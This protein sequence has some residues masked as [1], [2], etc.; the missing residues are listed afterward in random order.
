M[1][2]CVFLPYTPLKFLLE[3]TWNIFTK[4]N[5]IAKKQSK[6]PSCSQCKIPADMGGKSVKMGDSN[7][8]FKHTIFLQELQC[9]RCMLLVKKSHNVHCKAASCCT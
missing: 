4:T 7:E 9:D 3:N 1:Q 8:R 2:K 5:L 6:L